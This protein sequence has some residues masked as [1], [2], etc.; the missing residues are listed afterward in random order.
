MFRGMA[1]LL[2]ANGKEQHAERMYAKKFCAAKNRACNER[3]STIRTVCRNAW[4]R[5]YESFTFFGR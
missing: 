2:D 4:H 3:Y 5:D 1:T